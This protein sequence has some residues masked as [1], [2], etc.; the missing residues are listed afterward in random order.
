MSKVPEPAEHTNSIEY[1]A[2][3]T[4]DVVELYAYWHSC[5]EDGPPILQSTFLLNNRRPRHWLIASL[6]SFSACILQ[7][8]CHRNCTVKHESGIR[9]SQLGEQ[10]DTS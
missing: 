4:L 3:G 8:K 7:G 10:S 9:A 5:G 6:Y 1:C 2:L